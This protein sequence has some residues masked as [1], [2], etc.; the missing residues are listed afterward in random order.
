M[1]KYSTLPYMGMMMGLDQEVENLP[2]ILKTYT[3]LKSPQPLIS[4]EDFDKQ[5]K[6]L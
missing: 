2:D 5:S 6:G 1:W 4:Q 3:I